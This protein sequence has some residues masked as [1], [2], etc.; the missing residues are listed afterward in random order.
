MSRHI[1]DLAELLAPITP[2]LFLQKHWGQQALYIPGSR[3]KFADFFDEP[4]LRQALDSGQLPIKATGSGTAATPVKADQFDSLYASGMTLCVQRLQQVNARLDRFCR[5]AGSQ[6]GLTEQSVFNCYVSP[7]GHGFP[8]HCDNHSVVILQISGAKRWHYGPQPVAASLETSIFGTAED[9][10]AHNQANPQ[11]PLRSPDNEAL[12]EQVLRPGD[13]LFLPR[14]SWH[15]ASAIEGSVALTWSLYPTPFLSL[16]TR[17]LAC[18][19]QDAGLPAALTTGERDAL[20]PAVAEYL[21]QQLDL[22][23]TRLAQLTPEDL[24]ACWSSMVFRERAV[25]D[26][27]LAELKRMGVVGGDE[28]ASGVIHSD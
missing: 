4:A 13:L 26:A 9:L 11:Q 15:A 20:P 16:L 23:R 25:P 6:L 8:L 5:R 27:L 17:A 28:Q 14:G 10:Q 24:Q 2:E 1:T 22:L 12:T 19:F 7:D 21:G 3:E 18:E